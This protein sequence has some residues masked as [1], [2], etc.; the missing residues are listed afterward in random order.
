MLQLAGR[1]VT[2]PQID[3]RSR[4]RKYLDVDR[5]R[6]AHYV[7]AV[8]REAEED[9]L[10]VDCVVVQSVDT[11]EDTVC[12]LSSRRWSHLLTDFDRL[13]TAAVTDRVPPASAHVAPTGSVQP[14]GEGA[15]RRRPA[16]CVLNIHQ[17]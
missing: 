4:R 11:P 16:E 12:K 9:V 15:G 1:A 3:Y 8:R 14:V 13:A 17:M 7:P 10:F 6:G 5:Y 2:A